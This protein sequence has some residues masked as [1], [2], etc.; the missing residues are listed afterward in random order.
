MRQT[1]RKE[2]HTPI[3][4][5][6]ANLLTQTSFK[7]I[8]HIPKADILLSREKNMSK[9]DST[10]VFRLYANVFEENI[11]QLKEEDYDYACIRHTFLTTFGPELIAWQ[12]SP[13]NIHKITGWQID[14][15]PDL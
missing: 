4:K 6:F 3:T 8:K 13:Q 9:A 10:G 7:R 2:L 15:V 5:V 1:Y 12:Y 14:N 11:S